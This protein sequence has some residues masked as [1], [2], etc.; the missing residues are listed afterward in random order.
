M[1]KLTDALERHK[2][3][4]TIKAKMLPIDRPF[5]KKVPESHPAPELTI[6]DG[7]SPKLVV[8]SASGSMEAEYFKI[9]RALILFSK[10]HKT[11]R[12]IMITSAFPGEGKTFTAS[13]LAASMALGINEHVLLVDCDFRRPTLHKVLGYS[14]NEGL[15]DYLMGKRDLSDLIIR[16]R[17]ENLSLLTAGSSS[18]KPSEWLSSNAMKEFIDEVRERYQDRYII[19]DTT[20][21]LV[22]AESNVLANYVDGII[23]VVRAQKSPRETVKRS[24]ENLGKKNILGVVFN[25]YSQKH[26]SY[27]KYYKKYYK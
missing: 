24:I 17:I 4:K 14:N 22:T 23:F 1:G 10:D 7:I 3:E 8:H 12:T 6:P 15:H 20:P 13:N 18:L 5:I 19:I 9:L 27:Y 2:R 26:K 25:G 16:T 21:T 11:P